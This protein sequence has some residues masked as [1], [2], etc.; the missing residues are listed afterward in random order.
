MARRR[1]HLRCLLLAALLGLSGCMS[2]QRK[3]EQPKRVEEY[4]VPPTDETRFSSP[5]S[6]PKDT[7]NQNL[8]KKDIGGPPGTPMNGPRGFG[9]GGPGS[10]NGGGMGGRPY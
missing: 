5:I 9:A 2:T 7:L 4:V 10:M 6:F 8:I 1:T 3:I